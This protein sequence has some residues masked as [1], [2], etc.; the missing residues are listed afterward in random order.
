MVANDNTYISYSQLAN[1]QKEAYDGSLIRRQISQTFNA[2][3]KCWDHP[4]LFLW[5]IGTWAHSRQIIW[6]NFNDHAFVVL[7]SPNWVPGQPTNIS[8]SKLQFSR[9][10]FKNTVESWYKGHLHLH[11]FQVFLKNNLENSN[12]CTEA[13]PGTRR[14]H[15]QPFPRLP[16]PAL[17]SSQKYTHYYT[18]S[19]KF[20][21]RP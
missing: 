19:L 18:I 21:C 3:S 16:A 8:D 14:V 17:P 7:I 12:L 10:Y 9:L 2:E 5:P 4:F 6:R 15:L 13:I 11:S 20:W 1:P